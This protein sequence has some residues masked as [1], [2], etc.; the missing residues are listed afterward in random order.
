MTAALV[1][2]A[3]TRLAPVLASA[4]PDLL[5]RIGTRLSLSPAKATAGNIIRLVKSNK[6]TA[7]MVA[8]E[9]FGAADDLVKK[10]FE[11]EP[12]V[13]DA[14]DPFDNYKVDPVPASAAQSVDLDDEMAT[15]SDAIGRTGSLENLIVLKKAIELSPAHFAEYRRRRENGRRLR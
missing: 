1:V 10:F 15:I 14:L 4:T 9:V 6:L 11:A 5:A 7:A 8:F 3:A 13:K 12:A 2:T